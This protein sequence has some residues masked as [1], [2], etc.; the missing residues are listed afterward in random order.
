MDK[1]SKERVGK[2]TASNMHKLLTEPKTKADKEAGYLSETAKTYIEEVAIEEVT[3]WKPHFTSAATNHGNINEAEGGKILEML[4]FNIEHTAPQFSY[5]RGNIAATPDYIEY[6]GID[7]DRVFDV[8]CP[9]SPKSFF[10]QKQIHLNCMNNDL[11]GV[12]KPY[13]WQLQ[14]Q[15][16]CT[17]SKKS[18][19]LRYL[20]SSVTDNYGNVIEYDLDLQYRYFFTEVKYCERSIEKMLEA[21]EKAEKYK[22]YFIE[23]VIKW[24]N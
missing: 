13:F 8:K 12:P 18:V 2:F 1:L 19:L 3:G 6:Q 21:V 5:V 4:G 20:T 22:N 17:N 7:V 15:M 10:E 23:K 9:F 14:T 16:Y 24:Q 11:Q